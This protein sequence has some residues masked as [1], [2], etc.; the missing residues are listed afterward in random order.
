MSV[1]CIYS[2]Y[3]QLSVYC[4]YSTYVQLSVYCI[5]SAYIQLSVYCIYS[6]YIIY[7]RMSTSGIVVHYTGWGFQSPNPRTQIALNGKY[8]FYLRDCEVLD[9]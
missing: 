8:S 5:Y 6:T 3:I 7:S 9:I 1:Y 4:I 2:T